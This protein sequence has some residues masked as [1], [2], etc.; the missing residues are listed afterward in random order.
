MYKTEL[1]KLPAFAYVYKRPNWAIQ[2]HLVC[3]E[4]FPVYC[5]SNSHKL[6]KSKLTKLSHQLPMHDAQCLC[7]R[8]MPIPDAAQS[9]TKKQIKS[10]VLKH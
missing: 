2:S 5:K 9:V 4:R 8:T 6:N 10:F 7:Q 1:T 3:K